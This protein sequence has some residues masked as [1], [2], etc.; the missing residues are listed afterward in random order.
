M[1]ATNRTTRTT[2]TFRLP[3][4][5]SPRHPRDAPT[6]ICTVATASRLPR[7]LSSSLPTPTG[8]RA[9]QARPQ[10]CKYR[11]AN[12]PD[13]SHSLECPSFT[14]VIYRIAVRH[15]GA[16][17]VPESRHC[18]RTSVCAR[19]HVYVCMHVRVPL[20]PGTHMPPGDALEKGI[21]ASFSGVAR[22]FKLRTK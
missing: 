17:Y 4:M 5:R 12:Q 6:G 8:L 1:P 11:S 3:P 18:S 2:R 22:T 9:G 20:P 21:S 15:D 10:K 7:I 13:W 16:L 19:V 14:D